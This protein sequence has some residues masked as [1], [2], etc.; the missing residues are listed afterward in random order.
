[1]LPVPA[2][3]SVGETSK[4]VSH[5][6]CLHAY[7][8]MLRKKGKSY[9]CACACTPMSCETILAILGLSCAATWNA[10][11][12]PVL[13]SVSTRTTP[14]WNHASARDGCSTVAARNA[15]SARRNSRA[16]VPGGFCGN[17]SIRCIAA[18]CHIVPSRYRQRA[19]DC[20]ICNSALLETNL[21]ARR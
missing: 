4:H 14:S 17:S 12:A 15:A 18:A 11:P 7:V 6:K 9:V 8:S 21:A 13:S 1:M 20:A 10:A 2:C 3:R 19:C 16:P 5:H